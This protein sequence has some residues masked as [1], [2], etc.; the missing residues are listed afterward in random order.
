MKRIEIILTFWL[1]SLTLF[2]ADYAKNSVLS[3]GKWVQLQVDSNAIYK[4]TYEDIKTMGFTDPAKIKLY[5]YGGWILTQDFKKPYTDDLPEV[6]VWMNKGSDGVFNAGDY[7]L[8]YGRGT[9]KW[10]Y[11]GTI[12]AHENNP[13]ANYGYYFITENAQ[14]P[15]E[16]PVQDSYANTTSTV[17]VFDDYAIHEWENAAIMNSGRDLFGESFVGKSSQDFIFNIPGIANEP[18][19]VTLSFAAAPHASSPLTLSINDEQLL[20][21]SINGPMGDYVRAKL[22]GGNAVW[23][24]T[25]TERIKVN[26]S[27]DSGG[28]TIAYLNYIRFNLR[29]KLQLYNAFTFFRSIDSRNQALKYTIENT[30]SN[31]L[32]WDITDILNVRQMAT[33]PEGSKLTFGAPAGNDIIS[34][35]VVIDVAKSFPKPKV[36]GEVPNQDLHALPQTDM[37]IISPKVYAPLAEKLAERHR[38][39]QGLHVTVVQPEA[40]YNEFSSGTPDATAYRR[41]MKMFYDRAANDSEKPKYLLLYGDGSFDNRHLTVAGAKQDSK[42]Y[43]L[44]YQNDQSVD[45]NSAFG[46]DDYFGFLDDNE[47]LSFS[48]DKLDIGIGRFPVNSYQQA[49]NALNKVLNYMDNKRFSNW[50]NTVIFT[51]DD[52]DKN[53][54]YDH[55]EKADRLARYM[56]QNHPVY[57]VVKSYMDASPPVDSNG[58]RTYPAAKTKL[59]DTLVDGCFLMNYMGHGSTTSLSAEDMMNISNIRQMN[60]ENLPVWITGTCDFGWFDGTTTSA[61]EEVFL[62]KNSA[63]IALFTTTRP[64]SSSGNYDI[65]NQFLRKLFT[66]TDGQRPTLGDVIR[67]SKNALS[68]YNKLN[69]ILLGDPALVLNYPEWNVELQNINGEPVEDGKTVHFRA[70]DKMKLDGVITDDAGKLLTGFS[71][72]VYTAVFDGK[73][74]IQSLT[75][76]RNDGVT[77]FTFDDYSSVIY[78]GNAEVKDGRFTV[79]FNVP[80]EISYTDDTGKMIFYA[81]SN[82]LGTDAAGSFKNY[83]F[84]GTSDNIPFDDQGPEITAIFLN[85]ESFKDGDNVN[86]TPFFVA[87]VTDESGINMS[88]STLGHNMTVIIDNKWIYDNLADYYQPKDAFGGTAGFPIPT[89]TAGQHQLVFRVWDI[90]NN[91]TTDTLHFNVIPGLKPE[92]YTITANPNPAKINMWFQLE[93]NRPESMLEVEIQVCDLSG[94]TVWTHIESGYSGYQNAYRVEWDLKNNFSQRIEQ[95]I[96]VYRATIKTPN[97]KEV[98]QAKKL[99]VLGQ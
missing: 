26:V 28:Q 44:T 33:T 97:G 67:Q 57:R 16:I 23:T 80:Q 93:H 91:S 15:K 62:N 98:T 12:F 30:S 88:G 47:G 37:V 66:K 4:L 46:T 29:R 42:Y 75:T 90:M 36:I 63:G 69:F 89:L 82:T 55:V 54:S 83:I 25:K 8:F 87:T 73:Q 78:K 35:Y 5:G 77:H 84:S 32:I 68:G 86:E 48:S 31:S 41:F 49:E 99:I 21:T 3:Q 13:Y 53:T 7:L 72:N 10:A 96:Y 58:K 43:L 76:E 14:G 60:F 27:Y 22:G 38:E 20:K 9:V 79:E 95:G 17:T 52:I 6:A 71:G 34:E 39:V 70:L 24:G 64:V 61:G 56:E 59:M 40:I 81:H 11:N 51:A 45:E 19:T 1:F 92:L 85:A 74:T 65:C 18:A 50:K 2:S 94:R